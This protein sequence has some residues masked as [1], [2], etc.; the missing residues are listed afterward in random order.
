MIVECPYCEAVVASKI[1]GKHRDWNPDTD[2][3]PFTIALVECPGCGNGLVAGF[4]TWLNGNESVSDK[5]T[6]LWPTPAR[7]VDWAIPEI[8]RDSLEESE[9]CFRAGAYSACA[10]MCGR[11]LEGVCR[12]FGS[13]KNTM[14]GK[15]LRELRD[16]QVIDGRLFDWATE[17]QKSRN[18][19]AH[20]SGER[21]S[22]SDA[23]DL[24]D[25]T[26][27]ICEYVFVLTAKFDA[28]K[29]RQEKRT[30]GPLIMRFSSQP[31]IDAAVEDGGS[32]GAAE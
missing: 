4:T 23:Q 30:S 28:F 31:V 12:H 18:L 10:V 24:L 27:A 2:P 16:A 32:S 9:K 26:H 25:F 3:G 5:P 1:I 29:A 15:G 20:A 13:K 19:S 8:V 22:K 14:L 11:A 6:R 21:V 7:Y 17:L